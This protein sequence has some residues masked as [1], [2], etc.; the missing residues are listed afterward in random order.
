MGQ[1]ASLGDIL[2]GFDDRDRLGVVVR[3]PGGGL[4]AST[5]IL[6]AITTFYDIQRERGEDFFIYP[7]YFLFHVGQSHGDHG[8]LDIWPR[9]KEVIVPDDPEDLLRA[10]NDRG[11]TRLLVPDGVPGEPEFERQTRASATR[12][13]SCLAYAP[14]GQGHAADVTAR[15][16]D[17]TE[18]YVEAVLERSPEIETAAATAIRAVR[19]LHMSSGGAL[20][21]YRRTG[22]DSGL[23][24]LSHA[25]SGDISQ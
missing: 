25:R 7:D 13:V 8:M 21:S 12:I 10:I 17:K 16:H 20:E 3:E 23:S 1:P 11:I 18:S 14:H 6:A 4:G 2:P 24:L 5:L 22:L 15:G 19:R 9:H